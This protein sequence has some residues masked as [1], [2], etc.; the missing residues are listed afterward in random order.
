MNLLHQIKESLLHLAFPHICEGCG[1]DVLEM[2]HELCLKCLAALPHTNFHLHA[3][4][5]IEK[6]FWGRLPVQNAA[7]LFYFT[8]ESLMQHLMHQLKYRGNKE[9]GFYLGKLMGES[10]AASN[11]FKQIDG[12]VPLPLFKSK[13]KKRGYNQAT[14]LC[15][16]ISKVLEKPVW[17][18]VIHRTTYTDTQTKK[19]R[20]QRWQNM[21]NRFEL[22]EPGFVN[23]KHILLVDDVITTGA[24]LE[25]CGLE[26]LKAENVQLS[27]LTLC[28]SDH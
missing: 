26:L 1:T 12:L 18:D 13:E 25:S 19:N 10:I 28:F 15:E 24:T 16:G 14:V 4:N 2:E 23:G 27:L 21:E 8:K 11:R 9:L 3:D 5:P 7:A 17:K 20:I 22:N 6:I